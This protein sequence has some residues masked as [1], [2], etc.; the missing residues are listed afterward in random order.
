MPEYRVIL[1]RDIT[2]SCA[3]TVT[4]DNADAAED[5]A[6]SLVFGSD[7]AWVV[8]DGSCGV[9]PPYVTDCEEV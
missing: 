5:E 4:A 6:Y 8:D 1:T 9:E 2:E 3:V 7:H